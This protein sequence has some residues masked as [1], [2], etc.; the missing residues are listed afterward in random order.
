MGWH[1]CKT[2]IPQHES[3][4]TNNTGDWP[5][6]IICFLICQ[7][8]VWSSSNTPIEITWHGF[9]CLKSDMRL[10]LLDNLNIYFTQIVLKFS[11]IVMISWNVF[12]VFIVTFLYIYIYTYMC[13]YKLSQNFVNFGVCGFKHICTIETL[14]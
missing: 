7:W 3:S 2:P 12:S 14:T 10:W 9:F 6:A 1:F 8:L 4:L 13:V 5:T 11:D